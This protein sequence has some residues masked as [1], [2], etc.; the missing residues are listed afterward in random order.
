[1]KPAEKRKGFRSI[2]V[3]EKPF[4]WQFSEKIMIQSSENRNWLTVDFG[5]FDGWLYMTTPP[6]ER[7][8][9]YFP[10]SITP[11]FVRQAIEFAL[12]NNW[13]S[14]KSSG[15]QVLFYRDEQFFFQ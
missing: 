6:E 15:N 8:P 5:W 13:D 3:Q 12:E 1:M 9:E 7:P 2:V 11:D 14:G 4:I 10:K